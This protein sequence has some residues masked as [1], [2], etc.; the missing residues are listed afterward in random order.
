[1]PRV[2]EGDGVQLP[3]K[4]EIPAWP[5]DCKRRT[6]GVVG[7][8]PDGTFLDL[9]RDYQV[10]LAALM[11]VPCSSREPEQP[12]SFKDN[13]TI[14]A[15]G[16]MLCSL[17][18]LLFDERKSWLFP[19]ARY[20]IRAEVAAIFFTRYCLLPVNKPNRAVT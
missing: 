1:M 11:L 20:R 10:E 6:R 18:L 4:D 5:P 7:G 12:V 19:A 14:P 15:W 17:S 3:F 2:T 13:V 8:F 9:P 16:R